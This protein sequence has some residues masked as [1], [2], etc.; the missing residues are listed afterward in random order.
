M[1]FLD[2]AKIY[3]RSGNGGPGCI[4]FRREKFIDAGGPDGGNGGKGGDI[5]FECVAELN[6]LIDFRYTQHFRAESGE[7]GKGELRSGRGGDDLVIRV[8]IGTEI[9]D[10]DQETVLLD[11]TT[12]GERI[13]FMRGGDGGFGNTHY[14]SSTNQAPRKSTP[15]WKGEER[16]L[17]LR[18][19]LIADAGLVGMPNA[20]KS[21]F[22]AAC[23]AAKPK[24]ADYPFTTL[25]PNLGVVKAGEKEFV[26]ADIP[27]LIE[28]AHEGHGLGDRFLGHVER[29]AV[30]LH[31]IDITQDDP[32]KA[33]EIVR[34]ELEQYG[35]GLDEKPE[36]VALNKADALGPE[37]SEDQ[38]RNFELA[39]GVKPYI[40]S[41]VSKEGV[42]KV[43]YALSNIIQETR[44]AAEEAKRSIISFSPFDDEED[45]DD[46]SAKHDEGYYDTRSRDQ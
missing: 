4:S 41:G 35:G 38:A 14:K 40:I 8:P 2:Q 42:E 21:T 26:L 6:T 12:A 7:N 24:I 9:L 13:V 37:L 44:R 45:V 10:E 29:T 11:M 17:W 32:A 15:G 19:K 43:A 20:G 25:H 39:T 18:L 27:G 22:L 30:I 46:E 28:G 34:G 16:A 1:K 3:V 23:S 31:L 5:I 33:Y 36:I